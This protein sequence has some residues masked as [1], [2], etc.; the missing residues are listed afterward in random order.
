MTSFFSFLYLIFSGEELRLAHQSTD[1]S[2]PIVGQKE[3]KPTNSWLEK[4]QIETALD[5]KKQLLEYERVE[6]L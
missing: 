5:E 2:L 6:K 3:F 1:Q 4:K